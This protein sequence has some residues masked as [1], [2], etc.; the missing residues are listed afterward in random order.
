MALAAAQ[1]S[2]WQGALG[3]RCVHGGLATAAMERV[4][5]EGAAFAVVVSIFGHVTASDVCA[6]YCRSQFMAVPAA[7]SGE[8]CAEAQPVDWL[9][10]SRLGDDA[11]AM[12]ALQHLRG[13]VEYEGPVAPLHDGQAAAPVQM[14]AGARDCPAAPYAA[15]DCHVDTTCTH[16]LAYIVGPA[17][18][19]V[20]SSAAGDACMPGCRPAERVREV[21]RG[22]FDG[23]MTGDWIAATLCLRIAAI[24]GEVLLMAMLAESSQGV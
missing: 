5:I 7:E 21:D 11:I 20:P 19:C 9:V 2:G 1:A 13:L 15:F 24:V 14:T 23:A 22:V 8:V 16:T 4:L 10:V 3:A 18:H 6:A 17:E 12:L